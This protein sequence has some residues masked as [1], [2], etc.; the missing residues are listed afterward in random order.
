MRAT[1][2]LVSALIRCRDEEAG[3]GPLLDSLRGQSIGDRAELVVIDS[4]SRDRTVEEILRRGVEPLR[5]PAAEFSYGRALNR[6]AEAAAAEICVA[7]SAHALPPDPGWLERILTAFDDERVA[8]AFGERVG[9]DL[10]PLE[11]PLPQDLAHAERH[12]F[13]GY[14][15][16]A[17][18]FRRSLW[19]RRPFDEELAASEDKEWALHWLRQGM[20]VMLDPALAV[21]H[22]HRDEGPV[23]TFRRARADFSAYRAFRDVEPVS[24]RDVLVEWWRGAHT[25]RS[26]IRALGDPR[27]AAM[28]AGKYAALRRES[29]R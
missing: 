12:P 9:P 19:E 11:G 3:I 29:E 22:D 24:A 17:G 14:S 20:L 2:P 6:A 28:I 5:I 26:R 13:Y 8:C 25:H 10:R 4:G 18:G 7:I 21:H 27:R 23:R 15:N 16:S 1:R